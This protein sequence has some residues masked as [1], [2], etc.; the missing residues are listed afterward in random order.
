MLP[1]GR[2]APDVLPSVPRLSSGP[3]MNVEDRVE[4]LLRSYNDALH[5]WNPGSGGDGVRMMPSMWNEGSYA[6]LERALRSMRE[7]GPRERQ[8]WWHVSARYLWTGERIG[9]V[10]VKRSRL[11][12][13]AIPPRHAEIAVIIEMGHASARARLVTWSSAVRDDLVRAGVRE[14]SERMYGGD[15]GRVVVPRSLALA[16]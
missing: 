9:A 6:E 8:L 2:G 16:S 3:R 5:D 12:P 1:Q 13:V 15:V 10:M 14:I 11:G 7:G 4:L